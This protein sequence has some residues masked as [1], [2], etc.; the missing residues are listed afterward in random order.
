MKRFLLAASFV[1]G[2]L[3]A[4][5]FASPVAPQGEQSLPS[6]PSGSAFE[7]PR[8]LLQQGKNDEALAQLN[9]IA[10]ENPNLK[11]LSREF[12][13]AYYKTGDYLKAIDS[14]QKAVA[15]APD[16]KEAIQLLGLSNYL[17]GRPADAIPLLEKVQ[18]WYPRANVDASYILGVCHIQTKNY[19]QARKAFARMFEVPPDSAAAT[20]SRRE[21]CCARSLI[22]SPRSMPG[23][24]PRSI[25]SSP[26]RTSFSA[27]CT[28][29]SRE[30]PRP[31]LTF[32]PSWS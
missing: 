17:A 10:A 25:P 22:P 29:T 4:T 31:S 11:G 14:L 8:R 23:R 16:D 2:V 24:P 30:S 6:A 9:Q 3:C 20:C 12:G 32:K 28:C 13:V 1:F 19:D 26:W 18:G 7:T 21:S 15:E 27:S 5:G